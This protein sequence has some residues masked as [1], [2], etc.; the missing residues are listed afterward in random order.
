MTSWQVD[1][2]NADIAAARDLW[3]RAQSEGQ[4]PERVAQLWDDVV[5]LCRTQV[6]QLLRDHDHG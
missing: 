2:T 5:R 1:V 6:W 3:E 4:S